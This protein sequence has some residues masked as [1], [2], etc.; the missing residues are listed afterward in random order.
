MFEKVSFYAETVLNESY[1]D[2]HDVSQVQKIEV[3]YDGITKEMGF[4]ING[5][6]QGKAATINAKEV[7]YG[8][9]MVEAKGNM[10]VSM[11]PIEGEMLRTK[12]SV[13]IY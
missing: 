10:R 6:N 11:V 4:V 7:L 8:Y 1:G 9:I 5:K 13:Q 12:V 2:V 3:W